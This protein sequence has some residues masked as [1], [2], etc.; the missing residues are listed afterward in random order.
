MVVVIKL[1]CLLMG[2]VYTIDNIRYRVK[3]YGVERSRKLIVAVG[4]I[5]FNLYDALHISA[6][7]RKTR[8]FA[9]ERGEIDKCDL[10]IGGAKAFYVK[11][12]GNGKN[13]C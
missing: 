5:G 6:A 2:V 8:A 13:Q 12:I 1:T 7:A 11:K 9:A 4:F 3:G 10:H